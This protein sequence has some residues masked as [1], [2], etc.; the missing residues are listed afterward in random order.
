MKKIK[1]I[2]RLQ[3]STGYK[4]GGSTEAVFKFHSPIKEIEGF[5][6]VN[7][8]SKEDCHLEN[9]NLFVSR[10]IE[11]G[12]NRDKLYTATKAARSRF[13]ADLRTQGVNSFSHLTKVG[14]IGTEDI[15]GF[16]YEEEVELTIPEGLVELW[17]MAQG[18]ITAMSKE[19]NH[20]SNGFAQAKRCFGDGNTLGAGAILANTWYLVRVKMHQI[21]PGGHSHAQYTGMTGWQ[22]R[23]LW[24]V[25]T[26]EKPPEWAVEVWTHCPTYCPVVY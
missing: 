17:K 16:S 6:V 19:I 5:W 14:V 24:E 10:L 25:V 21:L 12:E 26:G 2:V 13:G 22:C 15:T 7:D 20:L 9:S 4:D 1:G 8:S 3:V 23:M 11:V 18:V